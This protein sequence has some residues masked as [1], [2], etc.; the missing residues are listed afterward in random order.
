[1][2]FIH[3]ADVHWGMEPDSDK[4]WSRERAQAIKDTFTQVITRARDLEVDFLFISGD[5]FHRQPLQRDLKE[6]NYLFSTIPAVHVVMIAG[7]HDRIRSNSAVLS[8]SWCPN[9]TFLMNEEMDHVYFS[10][11][12]TDVHG[13]SYHTAE[14][15]EN[16]IDHV[17]VPF[18]GRIHVLL[19]HGGDATHLPFDKNALAVSGFSYIALGHIHK[20]GILV[21]QSSLRRFP[22]TS[23]QDRDRH[24][25]RL[26]RRDQSGL[27]ESGSVKIPP[28]LQIPVYPTGG[29]HHRQHDQCGAGR[30]DQ[31]G[32]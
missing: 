28:P 14:I 1:M 9:V 32:D 30:Q 22:G 29:Q 31:P 5:L 26:L 19:A 25:W 24:P 15:R 10:D 27:P 2:K 23:G 11:C 7:N 16:R 17:E 8:F 20:P 12:N 21:E 3:T 18:D 6:I 4:P 13:F